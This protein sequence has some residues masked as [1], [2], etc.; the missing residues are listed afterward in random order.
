MHSPNFWLINEWRV[1]MFGAE[2]AMIYS[3]RNEYVKLGGNE[4]Q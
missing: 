2:V 1:A 3:N 4:G